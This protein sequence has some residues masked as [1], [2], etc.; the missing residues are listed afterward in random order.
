MVQPF[1]LR[2]TNAAMP[3]MTTTVATAPIT[4]YMVRLLFLPIA[5]SLMESLSDWASEYS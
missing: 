3:P 2:K 5:S 1:L 4:M